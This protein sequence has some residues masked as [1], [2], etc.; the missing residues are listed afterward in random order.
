MSKQLHCDVCGREI[1]RTYGSCTGSV[2]TGKGAARLKSTLRRQIIGRL[3]GVVS[4]CLWQDRGSHLV[5][6]TWQE[7]HI[8]P[9]CF[10][11]MQKG[12]RELKEE[13]E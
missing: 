12:I 7:K 9:D 10:T 4:F 1:K 8:C 6:G 3:L 13:Y 5:G 2:R 11:K